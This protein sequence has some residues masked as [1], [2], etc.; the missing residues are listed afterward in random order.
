MNYLLIVIDSFFI[1]C[2]FFDT[3][4]LF[5]PCFK[6][7]IVTKPNSHFD[8]LQRSIHLMNIYIYNE[9]SETGTPI[10]KEEAKSNENNKKNNDSK[11]YYF[12]Y[13]TYY[14]VLGNTNSNTWDENS[15]LIIKQNEQI[16]A[17]LACSCKK[18]RVCKVNFP[19]DAP[20]SWQYFST[21]QLNDSWGIR[22]LDWPS[23]TEVFSYLVL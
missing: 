17:V 4:L 13:G 9:T 15:K 18:L 8:I 19:I 5:S 7:C 16:M 22:T 2:Y 14:I 6:N 23:Y 11:V 3:L 1:C 21:P 20:I 12:S 10:Y